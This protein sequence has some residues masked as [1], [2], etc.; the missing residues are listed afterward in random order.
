MSL[1]DFS[2]NPMLDSDE[3]LEEYFEQITK[4]GKKG[5]LP[6]LNEILPYKVYS[7]SGS[8]FGAHKS[9]V[10]TTDGKHFVTVELD[11]KEFDGKKCIYPRTR[12]LPSSIQ[13]HLEYI[14][15]TEETG[16]D[17]IVKAVAVMKR[18]GSYNKLS[19]NCQDF[20]NKYLEAIGLEGS[21]TTVDKAAIGTIVIGIM[22]LAA[23]I[24]LREMRQN[25]K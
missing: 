5:L 19:N 23:V 4:L 1:T 13:P 12:E 25:T 8:H 7:I 9:I 24:A 20:C 11:F 3:H 18:F 10:L 14:G 22:C 2:V 17:L 15:E 16:L 6:N 21:L